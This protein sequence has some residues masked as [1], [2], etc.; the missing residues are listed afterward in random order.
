MATVMWGT[1]IA[2]HY[3]STSAGMFTYEPGGGVPEGSVA[4][5][6]SLMPDSA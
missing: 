3:D 5:R 4:V 1:E 6:T 2:Q